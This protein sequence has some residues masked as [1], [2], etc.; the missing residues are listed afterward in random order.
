LDL[1]PTRYGERTLTDKQLLLLDS[2]PAAHY[3]PMKAAI[4]AG[5]SDPRSAVRSLRKELTL[6]TEDLLGNQ[7]MKAATTLTDVLE[8]DKP[9][10]NIKEKINVAQ[11]ILDR[12]GHAK[13]VIQDITHTVKGG[14]FVLPPKLIIE[15]EFE[16]V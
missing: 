16:D 8:S 10:P 6:I 3:D 1:L 2:L 14:V 5:Y 12:T 9:I 7:A 11:D 4:L 13:K 15:G